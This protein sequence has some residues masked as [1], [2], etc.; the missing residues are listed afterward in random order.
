MNHQ[1]PSVTVPVMGAAIFACLFCVHVARAQ[2]VGSTPGA[3]PDP[4]TYRG[5]QQIQNQQAVPPSST[6]PYQSSQPSNTLPPPGGYASRRQ[7]FGYADAKAFSQLPPLPAAHNRLLG[8][9]RPAQ[10]A[11]DVSGLGA[12]AIDK[13]AAQLGAA[14]AQGDCDELFGRGLVEFDATSM[15]ASGQGGAHP[16]TYRGAGRRVAVVP[17]GS[18]AFGQ[19]NLEFDG[20]DRVIVPGRGCALERVGGVGLA[21]AR[22]ETG[23]SEQSRS[24]APAPSAPSAVSSPTTAAGAILVL[25]A[26]VVTASGGVMLNG[27][28][29][30]ITKRSAAAALAS[31]GGATLHAWA[32]A[33][34]ANTQACQQGVNAMTAN[35]VAVARTNTTGRARMPPVP[36][37]AYYVVAFA[38]VAGQPYLWNVQ[39]GMD[40]GANFLALDQRNATPLQ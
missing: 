5:S 31:A 20:A 3:I 24:Y 33:C 35:P 16:V 28:S 8:R 38:Q 25:D 7:A 29:L 23:R 22:P 9:W 40:P 36:A 32:D 6:A 27:A 30:F 39:V 13:L 14:V 17:R 2:E 34:R 18:D 21:V 15:A 37:G 12:G 19:L 4:S 26:S 10:R 1:A 11:A